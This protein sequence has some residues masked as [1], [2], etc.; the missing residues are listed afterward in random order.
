MNQLIYD[1]TTN[2]IVY[3]YIKYLIKKSTIIYEM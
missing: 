1:S 2:F 3:S